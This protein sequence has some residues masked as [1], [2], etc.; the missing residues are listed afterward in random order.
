VNLYHARRAVTFYSTG[1][2]CLDQSARVD[3]GVNSRDCWY[4]ALAVSTGNQ[5][6]FWVRYPRSYIS[7]RVPSFPPI[8]GVAISSSNRHP[9][10][11]LKTRG[12][13]EGIGGGG[14]VSAAPEKTQGNKGACLFVFQRGG[15]YPLPYHHTQRIHTRGPAYTSR[16][17]PATAFSA[18]L[19]ITISFTQGRN[20]TQAKLAYLCSLRAVGE[21][22]C[23]A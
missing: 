1:F 22:I 3:C 10:P 6:H 21:A 8:G 2:I 15:G 16:H 11:L 20:G 18:H 19:R 23:K 7:A 14:V 4:S 5:T 17:T 9:P 13:W 12:G